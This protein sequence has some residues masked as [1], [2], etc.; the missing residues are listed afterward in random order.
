MDAILPRT[1]AFEL[2]DAD[3]IQQTFTVDYGN[4]MC[5]RTEHER[6]AM[7][8]QRTE[9][10]PL[11]LDTLVQTATMDFAI[12]PLDGRLVVTRSSS[13]RLERTCADTAGRYEAGD[14]FLMAYPDEPY[15]VSFHPGGA[16][17][18]VIDPALLHR[19]AANA[20]GRKPQP[21]RFTSLD[22]H[23]PQAAADWWATYAYVSGLLESPQPVAP[24]VVAHATQLLAA[25]TLATFPNTALTDPTAGDR[26]DAS[27]ATLRR[28]VAFIEAHAG[29]DI[30]AA[31]VAAAANVSIRAVQLAFRRYHGVTPMTYLRQVRLGHVHRALL[32]A[33]PESTTVA[34]VAALW[35]FADHSRFAAL[36]RATYGVAPSSV[37]RTSG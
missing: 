15:T 32:A 5:L 2:T 18:C 10:G 21:L 11:A 30:S 8:Y 22:P 35:G 16:R 4:R 17:N 26:H 20:P 29:E 31:D 7:R 36:F 9:A 6:P 3:A 14:L 23:S 37:L 12:E 33:D 13:A 24:L 1:R 28:A 27:P 25:V 34:A 19:V